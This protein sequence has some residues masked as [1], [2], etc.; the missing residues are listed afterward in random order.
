MKDVNVVEVKSAPA[1]GK[2][3]MLTGIRTREAAQA[4]GAKRGYATVYF[5]KERE[6]VYADK[7]SKDVAFLAK[8]VETKSDHLVEMAERG[9]GLLEFILLIALVVLVIWALGKAGVPFSLP[10]LAL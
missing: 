7:L 2:P 1:I 6:R 9:C 10:P 5:W 4:W 8:Q 3:E